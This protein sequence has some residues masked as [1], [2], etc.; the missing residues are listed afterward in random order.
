M[1]NRP[2]DLLNEAIGKEV[3]VMLKGNIQVRGT[4]KAFDVHMNIVLESAEQL[5]NGEAKTKYGK[6]MVRGDN[7]I[8]ISP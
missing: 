4:L 8:L 5:E 2:F 7:V 6:L 3:L 1:A